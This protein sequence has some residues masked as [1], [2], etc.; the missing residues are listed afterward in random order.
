[1]ALLLINMT[2]NKHSF[3]KEQVF[4]D[5]WGWLLSKVHSLR[6]LK[7]WVR[8]SSIV[9]SESGMPHPTQ[10]FTRNDIEDE[11]EDDGRKERIN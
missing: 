8:Q 1:M 5:F 10:F 2:A 4:T 6:Y 7:S 9:N 3:E 11:G